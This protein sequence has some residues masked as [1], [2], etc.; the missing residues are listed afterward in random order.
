V[1][2]H[3]EAHFMG[4]IAASTTH[5][6]K[7]I[8]AVISETLGLLEDLASAPYK[9]A[10]LNEYID[11]VKKSVTIV[12]AQVTKGIA[13]VEDYNRFAH[14]LD[15]PMQKI[16]LHGSIQH[17]IKLCT[18]MIRLKQVRVEQQTPTSKTD[19]HLTTCPFY[20]YMVIFEIL[21]WLMTQLTPGSIV[22]LQVEKDKDT[23]MILF[24]IGFPDD[25][26][27]L[28]LNVQEIVFTIEPFLKE[29]E[30]EC[31]FDAKAKTLRL[32]LKDLNPDKFAF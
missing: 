4:R 3:Q 11:K 1:N 9:I 23:A 14:I 2:F 29:L 16:D 21:D 31:M 6:L 26:S 12:S 30:A 7:N 15:H 19:V 8:F 28:G 10:S 17:L 27:G 24:F 22:K 5:E 32:T 25:K 13:L 18:H 20:L